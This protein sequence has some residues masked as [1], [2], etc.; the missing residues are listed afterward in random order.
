MIAAAKILIVDDERSI[1]ELL[2]IVL[3]KEGFNV[4]SAQSAEE[5][6]ERCKAAE[7]DLVVSDINMV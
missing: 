1:R 3:K 4:T 7:F 5:G 6:L 2:E